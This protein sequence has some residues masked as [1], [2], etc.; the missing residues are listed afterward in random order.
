VQTLQRVAAIEMI[1]LHCRHSFVSGFLSQGFGMN[2]FPIMKTAITMICDHG[3]AV[4]CRAQGD[5]GLDPASRRLR[6]SGYPRNRFAGFNSLTIQ[7]L[8]GFE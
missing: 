3:R 1:S 4:Q 8:L 2:A 7:R 5:P 6:R